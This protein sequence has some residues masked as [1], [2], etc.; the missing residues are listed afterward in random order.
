MMYYYSR[1]RKYAGVM[2]MR[3]ACRRLEILGIDRSRG[4]LR[5]SLI[6]VRGKEDRTRRTPRDGESVRTTAVVYLDHAF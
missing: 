2:I 3:L 4:R 5:L 1:T 6:E